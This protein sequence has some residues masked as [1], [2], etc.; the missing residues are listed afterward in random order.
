MPATILEGGLDFDWYAGDVDS[1]YFHLVTDSNDMD[2]REYLL[3]LSSMPN[4]IK[5]DQFRVETWYYNDGTEVAFNKSMMTDY[6]K[7]VQSV[8]DNYV[9][10]IN[11]YLDLK[12]SYQTDYLPALLKSEFESQTIGQAYTVNRIDNVLLTY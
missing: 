2:L 8:M 7:E 10:L 12:K 1:G 6:E 4:R 3:A 9:S 5:A 11:K